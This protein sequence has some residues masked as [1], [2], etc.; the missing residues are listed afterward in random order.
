MRKLR[1]VGAAIAV[2]AIAAVPLGFTGTA[3]AQDAGDCG[4]G[5]IAAAANSTNTGGLIGSLLPVVAQV[6]APITAPVLSPSQESCN[7]N[8]NTVGAE[9]NVT[10]VVPGA[11]VGHA[12]GG[13]RWRTD[14]RR[15]SIRS[16]PE[17]S[18]EPGPRARLRRVHG[19]VS[20]PPARPSGPALAARGRGCY[21]DDLALAPFEC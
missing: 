8:T 1:L 21:L 13:R 14:L 20:G 18:T 17:T 5:G 11:H 7:S 19:P 16:V 9:S 4:D 2:T 10:V 12:R 15:L 6:I 3:G